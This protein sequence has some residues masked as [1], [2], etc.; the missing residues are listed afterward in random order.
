MTAADESAD[1]FGTLALRDAVLAA[2]RGSPTRFREDANSEEDLVR[3]GYRD[4]LVVELAQ[5]AADAAAR[6]GRPGRVRFRLRA[7]RLEVSNTGSALDAAG[8]ESLAALRASAK[9]D[10]DADQVGRFGVGFAAVLAVCDSPALRSSQGGVRFSAAET[11]AAVQHEPSL[12]AEVERR[13]HQVPILRLPFPDSTA[14]DAGYDTTVVLQLRDPDAVAL[15]HRLLAEVDAALLLALP[16]LSEVVVE[17]GAHHRRTL[18]CTQTGDG[19]VVLSD[20]GRSARWK[21]QRSGGE[22]P[23]ELLADR[24][25]EERSRRTWSLAWAFPVDAERRPT[26]LPSTV[27][28][29]LHAPTPT[30]E[31]LALPALLLASFPL[32]PSRRHVAA[33]PLTDFL[34]DRAADAYVAAVAETASECGAAA[35]VLVP[36][37]APAG[38]VD[39]RLRSA[40][41]TGL[42]DR[43]LVRAAAPPH[44]GLPVEDAFGLDPALPEVVEVLGL[45]L[46]GLVDADWSQARPALAALGVRELPLADALDAVADVARPP[47]WWRDLYQAL[48]SVE[49]HLLE[50][51]P[52]PLVDGRT[53][54]GPR[55]ALLPG[56]EVPAGDLAALGR[57]IVHPDA[58]HPLLERLGCAPA[59]ARSLLADRQ[60]LDRLP[61]A[62]AELVSAVLRTVAAAG[63]EP[64]EVPELAALPLPAADGER[65]A[66]GELVLPGSPLSE[67]RAAHV[68]VVDRGV[69]AEFGEDALVAVGVLDRLRVRAYHDVEIDP[70]ALA[71]VL[72]EGAAWAEDVLDRVADAGGDAELPPVA[73][74]VP[75]VLGLDRVAD[76]AWSRAHV[77]LSDPEVARALSAQVVVHPVSGRSVTVPGPSAWWLREAPLFDGVSPVG[78][79]SADAELPLAQ[80]YPVVAPPGLGE[81]RLARAI[82]VRSTLADLLAEPDGPGEVLD[83]LADADLQVSAE[84]TVGL[85]RAVA[86][87]DPDRWPTPPAAVRIP[88]GTGSRVVPAATVTVVARPHH[89]PLAGPDVL[90]G[91]ADVAE[92]LEVGLWDAEGAPDPVG[93]VSRAVPEVAR[94]WLPD[95]PAVFTEHDDLEVGG[96]SVAWWVTD[97]GAVHAATTEGLAR[98]LAW[99]GGSWESRY[100]LACLL[101]DPDRADE[102]ATERAFG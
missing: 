13:G 33:G 100:E 54:R 11:L 24:P 34:V 53:V 92:L 38:P 57:R 87:L 2:W 95:V 30:D 48:R 63:L 60:L 85:Y 14:P 56:V 17:T 90:P 44:R 101:A 91:V 68:P 66:A 79:H 15:V 84:H 69:V 64:E 81:G 94:S 83:R 55:T 59:D 8:V 40:V 23:P 99:A 61:D 3:G 16:S 9:R 4:R 86:A 62:D 35:A 27:P 80:L 78:T 51:L 25:A 89:L 93:G 70:D 18:G 21:V 22:V 19:D 28:P 102:L 50:G 74:D 43:A 39:G 49:P 6:V 73:P 97:D 75:T 65:V 31:P 72:L 41:L 77:L 47:E 52:V 46:D 88:A 42:R 71:G 29:L 82:G 12:A 20:D 36:D 67:V 45:V 7:D 76:D 1:V 10:G 58:S 26:R 98:A 37:R 5:N 32:D 96:R